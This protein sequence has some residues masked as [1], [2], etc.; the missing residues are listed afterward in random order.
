MTS[1]VSKKEILYFQ[2]IENLEANSQN[3]VGYKTVIR[4][5]DLLSIIVTGL[6]PEAVEPFN[7]VSATSRNATERLQTY[8]VDES[9]NIEMPLVGTINLGYKTRKEAVDLLKKEISKYVND[10]VINLRILNFTISVLGEV[11][12]PGTYT[13]PDERIT[14]IEA[15]GL[16][17]DMTIFGKRKKI[18]V[19][20][21][22]NN[23]KS[24]GELDITSI[25]IVNSPYY[26][27]QQNDIVIVSPNHARMQGAAFNR[28]TPVFISLAGI[29]I[30]VISV[31]S[32]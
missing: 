25:N 14:I 7:P 2:D 8:L 15:L 31:L 20:R 9:G 17:G 13:V 26:Y 16:S 1:C 5:N 10:P 30:S 23:I 22:E 19:I 28:N 24:Y 18:V 11:T 32:R 4:P 21:E 3:N 29:L 27:L 6:N 12:Q